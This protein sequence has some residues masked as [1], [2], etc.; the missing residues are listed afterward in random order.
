MSETLYYESA[1][2]LA[3]ESLVMESD[4]L[5]PEYINPAWDDET[6]YSLIF[7]YQDVLVDIEGETLT[8]SAAMNRHPG[9]W[10]PENESNLIAYAE[11]L[12]AR[13]SIEPMELE[14]DSPEESENVPTFVPLQPEDQ[15]IRSV[16]EQTQ[17]EK[18]LEQPDTRQKKEA[19]A[20]IIIPP[21]PAETIPSTFVDVAAKDIGR[22]RSDPIERK[23]IDKNEEDEITPDVVTQR[24]ET[25]EHTEEEQIVDTTQLA[26]VNEPQ[27]LESWPDAHVAIEIPNMATTEATDFVREENDAVIDDEQLTVQ[28]EAESYVEVS[29]YE[30]VEDPKIVENA[31][32]TS[33]EEPDLAIADEDLIELS[34]DF[35][36]EI[37][38]PEHIDILEPTQV[39]PLGVVAEEVENELI[40][41]A[42]LIVSDMPEDGGSVEEIV[43][44]IL[45]ATTTL[46]VE[47]KEERALLYVEIFEAAGVAYTPEL[48]ESLSALTVE[49]NLIDEI[50]RLDEAECGAVDSEDGS[51]RLMVKKLL[52]AIASI[53]QAI[54]HVFTVG[55]YAL[56]LCSVTRV[57]CQ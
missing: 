55:S 1:Y 19:P 35:G 44:E 57:G 10:T 54:R 31:Q 14:E 13:A 24:S 12:L 52:V 7:T 27:I 29:D 16:V 38:E 15:P 4:D 6:L 20:Q 18:D 36:P 34:S 26:D 23:I 41:L 50:E 33:T 9:P 37:D 42:E 39:E 11:G 53:I 22:L 48:I 2:E 47:T 49:W 3:P 51:A 28:Y 32:T 40:Q 46:D 56:R 25:N 8:L 43:H 21:V 5:V 17:V 45:E 30:F